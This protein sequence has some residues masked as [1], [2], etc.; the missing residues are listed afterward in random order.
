MLDKKYLVK[1]IE[2]NERKIGQVLS[3]SRTELLTT[4]HSK[5]NLKKLQNF[6]IC[7]FWTVFFKNID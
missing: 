4:G 6:S 2:N 7:I 5:N 1:V 3:S